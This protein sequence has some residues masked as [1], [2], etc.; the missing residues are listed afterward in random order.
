MA[1]SDTRMYR[2]SA[3]SEMTG[4]PEYVLRQWE[5]R[6]P[7]LKP[8]RDRANR[9]WY[10]AADIDIVR[11]IKFLMRHEGMTTEGARKLL[12]QE[13]RGEGRPRTSREI[14][15]ILDTM[16]AEIRRMLAVLDET[17]AQVKEDRTG[18]AAPDP[19]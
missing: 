9:R 8:K 16:E 1:K 2:I 15:D 14:V 12:A 4:V 19:P 18:R 13:L 5:D 7:Q 3:V 6:F 17:S 11:R 10:G